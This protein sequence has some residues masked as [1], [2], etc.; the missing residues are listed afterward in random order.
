MRAFD[1]GPPSATRG[2]HS[3]AWGWILFW[4]VSRHKCL[5]RV[6]YLEITTLNVSVRSWMWQTLMV[7][8]MANS[9]IVLCPVRGF[10]AQPAAGCHRPSTTHCGIGHYSWLH[11]PSCCKNE[12]KWKCMIFLVMKCSLE[13]PELLDRGLE[14]EGCATSIFSW[15]K[16]SK[17]LYF[18][19][20]F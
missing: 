2:R 16:K 11:H 4:I 19:C 3:N 20:N 14:L 5:I 15:A 7:P 1:D 10:E 9:S 12:L 18:M 17:S 8:L 13:I 6:I